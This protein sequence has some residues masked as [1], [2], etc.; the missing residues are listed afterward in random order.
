MIKKL[1]KRIVMVFLFF[2]TLCLL[3][4]LPKNIDK[5]KGE[6]K[7]NGEIFTYE[8]SP[9]SVKFYDKNGNIVYKYKTKKNSVLL[10]SS[11]SKIFNK[12]YVFE[13]KFYPK[14]KKYSLFIIIANN[15]IPLIEKTQTPF[16]SPIL[17]E[18]K[19]SL[20]F[21]YIDE[22]FSINI[23]DF[24]SKKLLRKIIFKEPIHSLSFDGKK[25][26]LLFFR[27]NNGKYVKTSMYCRDI[28]NRE[29]NITTNAYTVTRNNNIYNNLKE[30]EKHL[31]EDFNFSYYGFLGFGDSITFGYINREEAPDKGYVPRLQL[32]VDDWYGGKVYNEGVPG[33]VTEDGLNRFESVILK[34]KA[35]YLLFHEGTNDALFVRR[36]PVSYILF[37]IESMIKISL[38]HSMRPILTT[39]IPRNGKWGEGIYRERSIEISEGIREMGQKYEIPVIDLFNIFLNY[40]ESDGG[41]ESLMSDTVHP[42]EKGYQLMAE[43]WYEYLKNYPPEIPDIIS[44]FYKVDPLTNIVGIEIETSPNP[45]PDFKCL[46]IYYGEK[47]T[48]IKKFY[49]NEENNKIVIFLPPGKIYYIGVK[50]TDYF[51]NQSNLSAILK[52]KSYR[53]FF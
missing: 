25:K 23:Y 27:F 4:P 51:N 15:K 53:L 48:E 38:K 41:Y 44:F 37:N 8:I 39:I 21:A 12:Y 17:I 2:S 13:E 47:N 5:E 32:M 43:K 40:P 31:Y 49:K 46:S 34:D 50:A 14:S 7:N 16:Y 18:C 19:N 45:D 52:Y 42:S 3:F 28:N 9:S 29:K 30:K 10:S 35:K 36:F 11:Y 20:S 1:Q 33:E 24:Q 22:S 6:I 26:L